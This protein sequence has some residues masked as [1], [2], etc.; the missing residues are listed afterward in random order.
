MRKKKN[1]GVKNSNSISILKIHEEKMILF[2]KNS[3]EK[4]IKESQN[5]ITKKKEEIASFKK[6]H[7]IN[8]INNNRDKLEIINGKVLKLNEEIINLEEKISLLK[9]DNEELDYIMKTCNILNKYIELED[10]ENKLLEEK[11][12]EKNDFELNELNE[13]NEIN[14]IS[15]Q[16]QDLIDAYMKIVDPT[17]VTMRNMMDYKQSLCKYCPNTLL[18]IENGGGCCHECGWYNPAILHESETLSW[19][20]TQEMDYRPVFTYQ[21]ESHLDEWLRRFQAKEHREIPKE[22]ITQVILESQKERIKDLNTLTEL[23]VK[24]YLKKLNQKD[25]YDNVISIIN[26]INNRPAF[27][28]TS[29]IESKIKE[30]FHKIQ[31]PFEKHKPDTRKSMLSYSYLLNKF[32]LILDLPEFSRYFF[33]LKSPEKLRQQ[34]EIFKKIVDEL[35][36]KDPSIKWTFYP[37]C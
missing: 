11:E 26:K 32:F 23:Q 24:K 18:V 9:T 7:A 35:A 1:C 13:L 34:D 10:R 28:L 31:A 30:M 33:L 5:L 20:Q 17:F 29:E 14:E 19:Q 27:K 4:Q 2:S 3:K 22:I 16:K 36:V 15:K 6:D 12:D 25:Y 37:S 8:N 21:R